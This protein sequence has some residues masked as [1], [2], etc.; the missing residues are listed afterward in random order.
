MMDMEDAVSGKTR[1]RFWLEAQLSESFPILV[2]LLIANVTPFL[3]AKYLGLVR[4]W[5]NVDYILLGVLVFTRLRWLALMLLPFA[6]VVDVLT[7]VSQVFP[8]ARLVDVAYLLKFTLMS[9]STYQLLLLAMFGFGLAVLCSY[10]LQKP[11]EQGF[12]VSLVLLN[13]AL[14]AYVVDV[15]S[16]QSEKNGD[17]LWKRVHEPIASSQLVYYYQKSTTGF[18][19]SL[20]ASGPPFEDGSSP[21]VTDLWFN[22]EDLNDRLLLIVSESWGVAI[23]PGIQDELLRPLRDLGH[24]LEWFEAG[25]EGFVGVTVAGEMREL[26][27]LNPRYFNLV[28]AKDEFGPCLPNQLKARSYQTLAMHGAAGVMYDRFRWYPLV[29]FDET[30]FFE[31]RVWPGRCYS[32]PGACDIHMMG[33]LERAFARPGKQ[34]FYWLTLNSHSVYDARDIHVDVFDCSSFD[35]PASSETC[36]NLKL[37]AQFFFELAETL[38][39]PSMTGVEVLVVGDH[40]PPLLAPGE[41]D[42]FME[43]RVAWVHLKLD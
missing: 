33:E 6:L 41:A 10:W 24:R 7:L 32:F 13:I 36:R 14:L 1:N 4:P 21:G 18:F 22:N 28:D 23:N 38:K 11:S 15:Y 12:K 35:I 34:F 39:K 31:S 26:C 37:H 8:V 2:S 29:G 16:P 17:R 25:S 42:N 27:Q 19:E 30:V 40:P 9:S 20:T 3:V 43:N 5:V